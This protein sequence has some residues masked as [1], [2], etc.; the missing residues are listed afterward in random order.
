[1]PSSAASQ[2]SDCASSIDVSSVT[3]AVVDRPCAASIARL[4]TGRQGP[5]RKHEEQDASNQERDAHQLTAVEHPVAKPGDHQSQD[6][7]GRGHA[8]LQS[9]AP[10]CVG[11]RLSL[12]FLRFLGILAVN[13]SFPALPETESA[14]LFF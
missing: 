1:M 4:H 8:Y 3:L 5:K 10:L 13:C 7:S 11:L 14:H 9:T 12:R 6:G 2:R